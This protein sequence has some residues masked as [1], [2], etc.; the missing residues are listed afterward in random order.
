MKP[1]IRAMVEEAII[2][3]P[4]QNPFDF[5]LIRIETIERFAELVAAHEREECSRICEALGNN[6][7]I[8]EIVCSAFQ[9]ADEA[10]RA[11]G[12]EVQP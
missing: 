5:R 6:A 10:I 8:D 1:D 7:E 9:Q 2:E 4:N 11:R 3:F 12:K